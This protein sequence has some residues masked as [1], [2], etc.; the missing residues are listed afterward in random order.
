MLNSYDFGQPAD[1]KSLWGMR[2]RW[3]AAGLLVAFAHGAVVWLAVSWRLNPAE[4]AEPAQ[5]M[6]IELASLAVDPETAE[7]D[8]PPTP[9]VVKTEPPPVEEPVP[10]ET[11]E[12]PTP[13]PE[14]EQAVE[15]SPPTTHESDV[16]METAKPKIEPKVVPKPVRE[17]KP[18]EPKREV[19]QAKVEHHKPEHAAP[20]RAAAS[21]LAAQPS[22]AAPVAA[23]APV[24]GAAIASWR[25]SLIAHLNRY[26]RFPAGANGAGA[27]S[28]SFTIDRSGRV[29]SSSLVRSSGDPAL[30]GEAVAMMRR[31]SPVPQPPEN[32]G[33]RTISL[34]VPIR[35]NR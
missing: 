15:A 25:G 19:R 18:K 22:A 5:S 17:V 4:A 35:F 10:A 8:A 14:L 11:A 20:P 33:G 1:G 24:S 16:V 28:V 31:A 13:E 32:M 26:K 2:L 6:I 34:A 12:K 23:S 9:D 3:V 29:L 7:E 30:D 21:R 27:A